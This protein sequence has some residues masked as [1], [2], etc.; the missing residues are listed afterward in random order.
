MYS[1]KTNKFTT[2]TTTTMGWEWEWMIEPME[3]V[4]WKNKTSSDWNEKKNIK[5]MPLKWMDIY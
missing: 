5:L 2:T 4:G 3:N 1:D